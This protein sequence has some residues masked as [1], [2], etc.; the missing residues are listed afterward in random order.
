ML[1]VAMTQLT[2]LFLGKNELIAR[3]AACSQFNGNGLDDAYYNITRSIRAD[4]DD[5]DAAASDVE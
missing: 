5:D 2:G 1:L 3:P 4:N